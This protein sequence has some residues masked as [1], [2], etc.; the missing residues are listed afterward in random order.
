MSLKTPIQYGINKN[1]ESFLDKMDKE[2]GMIKSYDVLR[3]V[4]NLATK[5]EPPS[6]QSSKA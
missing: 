5:Q 2:L 1:A 3:E 4:E 6:N